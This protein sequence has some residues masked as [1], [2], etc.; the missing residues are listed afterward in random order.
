MHIF[1]GV[2]LN[3]RKLD[4]WRIYCGLSGS[5]SMTL[6][7]CELKLI[8]D[9]VLALVLLCETLPAR[10]PTSPTQLKALTPTDVTKARFQFHAHSVR[11]THYKLWSFHIFVFPYKETIQ[12]VIHD[13][14]TLWRNS[15]DDFLD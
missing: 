10:F 11:K 5:R 6:N 7:L 2:N 3:E 1:S 4:F 9:N 13:N 8:M 15:N 14:K 12:N